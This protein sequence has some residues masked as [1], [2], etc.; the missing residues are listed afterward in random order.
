LVRRYDKIKIL[1]LSE[2]IY[3]YRYARTMADD[4]MMVNSKRY[5]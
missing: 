2:G 3:S 1:C 4:D 5:V